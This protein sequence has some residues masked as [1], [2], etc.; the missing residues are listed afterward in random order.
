MEMFKKYI[1]IIFLMP[2][3]IF[4]G[5]DIKWMTINML[6][7]VCMYESCMKINI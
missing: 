6:S 2:I 3:E 4:Y 1:I 5:F 7:E